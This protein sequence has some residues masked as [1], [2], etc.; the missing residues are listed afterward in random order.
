M[1]IEIDQELNAGDSVLITFKIPMGSH[2]VVRA[3]LRNRPD[4]HSAGFQFMDLD[5]ATK[6]AIRNYVVSP[7][8]D[9][10]GAA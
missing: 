3:E 2:I 8:D 10:P 1:L 7:M 9:G 4:A 6:R 5:F